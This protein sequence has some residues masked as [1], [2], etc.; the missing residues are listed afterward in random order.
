MY[1]AASGMGALRGKDGEAT[2]PAP[3]N[4]TGTPSEIWENLTGMTVISRR[5]SPDSGGPG[6]NRGGLGQ[7]V[8]LRNDTGYPMNVSFFAQWTDFPPR[9]KHG[10]KSGQVR[11]YWINGEQV[12]PR[13]RFP[14]KAGDTIRFANAGGGGFGDPKARRPEK[15]EEDLRNGFITPEGALRDYGYRAKRRDPQ[16]A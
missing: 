4:I 10:G 7:E 6:E 13:G 11:R 5:L 9:G 16:P 2:T 1:F 8:E 14:L 3:A 12:N 15:I